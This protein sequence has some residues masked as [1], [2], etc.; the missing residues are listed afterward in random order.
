MTVA[1]L[2]AR[3]FENPVKLWS[4]HKMLSDPMP[5]PRK[6]LCL[7]ICGGT[8]TMAPD[9]LTGALVPSK[10][11]NQLLDLVPELKTVADFE[12]LF[13]TAVDSAN[14][15]PSVWVQIAQA[16]VE[17]FDDFDGFIVTHG[18]DTM[19]YTA[20]ALSFL[21]QGLSKPV[22]LT[23]AQT[24]IFQSVGSDARNN[25][26]FSAIFALQDV[27][28]VCI[29]FGAELMRGNRTRKLS[30]F[31]FDAF[32]S[33]NSPPLGKIG[34]RPKLADHRI[35]REHRSL[36]PVPTLDSRIFLLKFF[37]GLRPEFFEHILSAGYNGIV[38]EG[39]GA[40]NLP[41]SAELSTAIRRTVD[42]GVPV[43]VT[44]QCI[45]GAADMFLYQGG[46][47]AI[48][49]GAISARDMTSEA[50]VTKLYW[51]LSQT[52]NMA[53]I[54]RLMKCCLVGEISE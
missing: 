34:I 33:I 23:G 42:S 53:E 30:E 14:I 9:P 40:G 7:V 38:I 2:L 11:I 10:D 17:R 49:S 47:S 45:I 52:R 16:I 5:T 13:I 39:F 51:V 48:N 36:K 21:L 32:K 20:S 3:I 41:S 15:T 54:E 19:A 44:T 29:F 50:A 28:E 31:D 24:P 46:Q 25:L 22:I 37:P 6:K 18:T 1:I 4:I 8:I 12:S 43:I 27:A 26:T 35:G